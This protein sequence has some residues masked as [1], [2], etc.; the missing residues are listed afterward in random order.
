MR[1][2]TGLTDVARM[3][4]DD[5]EAIV[6]A[7]SGV[8]YMLEEL[9]SRWAGRIPNLGAIWLDIAADGTVDVG[10]RIELIDESL[11]TSQNEDTI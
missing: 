3:I 8:I 10:E 5:G 9:T 6:V 4:P 1:T 11:E 2:I 7:H